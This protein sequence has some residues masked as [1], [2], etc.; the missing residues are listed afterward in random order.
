MCASVACVF[1]VRILLFATRVP[2]SSLACGKACF[3]FFS[4]SVFWVIILTVKQKWQ[5]IYPVVLSFTGF[6]IY[7]IYLSSD[8]G[9][10]GQNGNGRKV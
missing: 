3:Y 4:C 5:K 9:P 1:E 7:L 6:G 10:K 2:S 8:I